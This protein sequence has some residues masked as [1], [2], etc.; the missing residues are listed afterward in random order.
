MDVNF[1]NINENGLGMDNIE[2]RILTGEEL[3]EKIREV[4]I[5][6]FFEKNRHLLGY[7]NPVKSLFTVVKEFVDNSIDAC[8]E[9]RILPTI[10]VLV[11]QVSEN[12]YRVKVEDNGPGIHPKKVPIAFAKFLVGSKFYRLRQSIGTQGIGAKGAIL[13]AQLTTGKSAKVE[14]STGNDKIHYFEL[15]IDVLKNEPIILKHEVRENPKKWHGTKIEVIVEGRYIE[16]RQS[17]PEYLKLISIA[18]PYVTITFDGP[19]GVLKFKR[20]MPK[21]PKLPRE[22]KPHP[23]GVELGRL[24]RMLKMTKSTTVLNFLM[25][26]FSRVGRDSALKICK[27][28]KIDPKTDPHKL[29]HNQIEKLHKAMTMVKLLSPPMDCLS[30]INPN[31]LIEALK[32]EYPNAEFFHAVIRKPT[33]YRGYPFQVEAAIVYGDE[34]GVSSAKLIRLANHTPLLYNQSDCVIT[35]AVS[36]TNWRSYGVSQSE[37]SIPQAPMIIL[38]DFLSVWIPYKSEGKEAIA[39]YPEILKE[40]KLALQELGRNLKV[41]MNKKRRE[42]EKKR[43]RQIFE[44]YLPE[45]VSSIAK[46]TDKKEDQIKKM[47]ENLLNK[48]FVEINNKTKGEEE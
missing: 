22:I 41:F 34:L 21:L 31:Y 29:V 4:S 10:K 47:I 23:Y 19:N 35:K 14:T 5:A 7:E 3:A 8:L 17:I 32:R 42:I 39:Q 33:V 37:G 48:K 9:A 11:K 44:R 45:V 43:K 13:Y 16:K 38:V 1:I 30:P 15:M 26:E 46:I 36:E 28:A 25:N 12:R 20:V 40:I 18:N 27:L 2:G 6:E 24:K